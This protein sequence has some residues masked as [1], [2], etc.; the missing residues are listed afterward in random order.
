MR[1]DP[2]AIIIP[3]P[4]QYEIRAEWEARQEQP[5]TTE[6][7]Y[8]LLY[9]RPWNWK[10]PNGRINM[11][12]ERSASVSPYSEHFRS[13]VE[14]G[15]W[16]LVKTLYDRGYLPVSS[17]AGHRST[18]WGEWD[19]FF[20]YR[21]EPYVSIA[22]SRELESSVAKELEALCAG[23]PVHISTTHSQ[24]NM[25]GSVFEGVASVEKDLYVQNRQ[26]EY[27][28]LNWMLQRNY[29]K[30]SYVN[31]RINPW[32]RFSLAHVQRTQLED[33]FIS[34][35]AERLNQLSRYPL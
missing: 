14:D 4:P 19:T 23:I 6:Q 18:L 11:G 30:W 15:I 5:L 8:R 17:C 28:G 22:V 16:P 35:L 3:A 34:L 29:D 20:V 32:K 24:A 9:D 1:W 31:L 27:E 26:S 10:S 33:T 2:P 12:G 25:R 21:S 7:H 13:Q